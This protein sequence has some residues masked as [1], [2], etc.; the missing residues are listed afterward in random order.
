MLRIYFIVDKSFSEETDKMSLCKILKDLKVHL[1]SHVK[2]T[3]PNIQTTL[4]AVAEFSGVCKY[5]IVSRGLVQ[6]SA[7]IFC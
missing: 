2:Q 3:N 1:P 5:L 7:F 6:I 4:E